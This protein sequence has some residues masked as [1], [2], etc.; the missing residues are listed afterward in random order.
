LQLSK[1][2]T[3]KT[4]AKV[5]NQRDLAQAEYSKVLLVKGKLESL[6]R[7]LQRQNKLVKVLEFFFTIK[8]IL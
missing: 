6:C 3:E 4:F 2:E 7:E 8:F 5:S 1:Q